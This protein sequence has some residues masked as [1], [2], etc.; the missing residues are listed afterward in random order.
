MDINKIKILIITTND[1]YNKIYCYLD[2]YGY[3]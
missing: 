3:N 1:K 2:V